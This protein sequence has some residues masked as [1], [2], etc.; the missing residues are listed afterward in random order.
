MHGG[1]RFLHDRDRISSRS[2]RSTSTLP[3]SF[4]YPGVRARN[5]KGSSEKRLG[6][7][8]KHESRRSCVCIC[9]SEVQLGFSARPRP[10]LLEDLLR[11]RSI[12]PRAELSITWRGRAGEL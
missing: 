6:D 2:R 10:Q 12:V 8:R 11:V 1:M 7:G 4:S 5:L 9:D 3:Q